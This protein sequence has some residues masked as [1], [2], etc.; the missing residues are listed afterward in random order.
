MIRPAS[1]LDIPSIINLG[2][3]YV[4]EEVKVVG[5]HS[6]EWDAY[7]S[8]HNLCQSLS[9]DDMF[10]WVAVKDGVLVGFLWAASH[11]MAPWNTAKV[12]SDLL[13][14]IVPEHRGTRLGYR[15]IKEYRAWAYDQGCVEARL[16]VAS[17]IN[18]ER[19]GRM[20]GHLGF[21]PFGTVYN[22]K[23]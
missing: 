19:V 21:E 9:A 3:R 17:G 18:E 20:Y 15:L 4:E 22:Y 7:Q 8:S 6:F 23:F 11:N 1:F 2:D 14:Y 12:A 16:S 5:H 13:F 10:L